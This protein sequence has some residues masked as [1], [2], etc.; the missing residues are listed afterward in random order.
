MLREIIG[1]LNCPEMFQTISSKIVWVLI[2]FV[3]MV[4][5]MLFVLAVGFV[6]VSFFS[7]PPQ[8]NRLVIVWVFSLV[9]LGENTP[10]I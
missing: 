9:I 1:L 2:F 6:V 10:L 3:F 8:K 4:E 5:R 7:F